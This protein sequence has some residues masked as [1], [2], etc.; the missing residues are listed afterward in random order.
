MLHTFLFNFSAMGDVKFPGYDFRWIRRAIT[1]L[2]EIPPDNRELID[3]IYT[4]CLPD[5]PDHI[6]RLYDTKRWKGKHPYFSDGDKKEFTTESALQSICYAWDDVTIIYTTDWVNEV[7]A[8]DE[9]LKYLFGGSP[10]HV[11]LARREAD[12]WQKTEELL[13]VLTDEIRKNN[14]PEPLLGLLNC[15]RRN[16]DEYLDKSNLVIFVCGALLS[17]Y[18]P[19]HPTGSNCKLCR[20]PKRKKTCKE[21]EQWW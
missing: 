1:G 12:S 11:L 16:D 21:T 3:R 20:E 8:K 4:Y 7:L 9:T 19:I 14:S 2:V 13:E 17:C 5:V 15:F 10:L 6:E 18:N